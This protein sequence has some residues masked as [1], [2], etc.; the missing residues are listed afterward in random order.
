MTGNWIFTFSRGDEMLGIIAEQLNFPLKKPDD[1]AVEQLDRILARRAFRAFNHHVMWAF[2][3]GVQD[4]SLPIQAAEDF[5][6]AVNMFVPQPMRFAGKRSS[7]VFNT[8]MA[9]ARSLNLRAPLL[10]GPSRNPD[11]YTSRLALE[12]EIHP[13]YQER[14]KKLNDLA[15][16]TYRSWVAFFD[17]TVRGWGCRVLGF[18][19][20]IPPQAVKESSIGGGDTDGLD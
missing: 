15:I 18:L 9:H 11:R 17:Y 6:E 16:A 14:L 13:E 3:S 12:H 10:F 19:V 5:E 2:V 8:F 7:V 1:P 4:Q 20:F